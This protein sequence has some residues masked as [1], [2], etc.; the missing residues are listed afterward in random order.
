MQR[1][2]L[3]VRCDWPRSSI[4]SERMR[5]MERME[6]ASDRVGLIKEARDCTGRIVRSFIK[7]VIWNTA[8]RLCAKRPC[9][10]SV[11]QRLERTLR[12]AF[13]TLQRR[14]ESYLQRTPLSS[15][16]T[17]SLF[18]SIISLFLSCSCLRSISEV[19]HMHCNPLF[20]VRGEKNSPKNVLE[21][22][23]KH[24]RRHQR[25]LNCSCGHVLMSW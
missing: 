19:P 21:A 2:L 16:L 18:S 7:R 14:R 20:I 17:S 8:G 11:G 4:V 9:R 6:R 3:S 15:T 1:G 22:C 24:R 12:Q 5:E 13:H 10:F 25:H 23:W